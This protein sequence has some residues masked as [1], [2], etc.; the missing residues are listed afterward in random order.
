MSQ[1]I[2]FISLLLVHHTT[3]THLEEKKCNEDVTLKCPVISGKDFFS[4]TWYKGNVSI[5]RRRKNQTQPASFSRDVSF[6]EDLSLFLPKVKPEDTGTY[7][8]DI[9]ANVGQRNKEGY[10]RLKVNDV[11]TQLTN[12]G[13]TQSIQ[14]NI[15]HLYIHFREIFGFGMKKKH[16]YRAS[17]TESLQQISFR[18]E[19]IHRIY[20]DESNIEIM[21]YNII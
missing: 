8:C 11:L 13:K 12:T 16:N 7:K 6:G 5:I 4:L 18:V 17:K 19:T 21:G 9:R 3:Q 2:L 14:V 15:I 20:R 1:V 10:V